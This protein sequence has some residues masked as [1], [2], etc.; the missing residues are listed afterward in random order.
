MTKNNIKKYILISIVLFL[1]IMFI[2]RRINNY[3]MKKELAE[4]NLSIIWAQREALNPDDE[5]T[6]TTLLYRW[7][8]GKEEELLEDR[9]IFRDFICN[10]DGTRLLSLLRYSEVVEYNI[11]TKEL[12][13]IVDTD[14]LD[15]FLREKG[16]QE[17]YYDDACLS[18][19]RYYDN[20][21]KI[22]VMYG[23]FIIGYSRQEGLEL[24]YVLGNARDTYS[25]AAGDS[26]LLVNQYGGRISSCDLDTRKRRDLLYKAGPFSQVAENNTFVLRSQKEPITWLYDMDSN[27]FKKILKGGI[28]YPEY[29]ITSDGRYLLWRDN[30]P[31]MSQEMDFLYIVDLESGRKVR[32]KKWG[33]DVPVSGMTW[34]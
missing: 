6:K 19:P 10:G 33:F 5:W 3:V 27:R 21:N 2:V 24:I 4:Q 25:W 29:K 18:C 11:E 17:E 34:S 8:F 22:S 9:Y 20:E 12:D 1:S 28:G 32:L 30:I 26:V 7:E 16:Y 13:Y 31:V 15:A 23:D 14:Q